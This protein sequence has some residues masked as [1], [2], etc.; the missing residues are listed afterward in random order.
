MKR[1][2]V[3]LLGVA[4]TASAQFTR[5]DYNKTVPVFSRTLTL[6]ATANDTTKP[7]DISE[8]SDI[9]VFAYS[10]DSLKAA[11][12]YRLINSVTGMKTAWTEF[13]TIVVAATGDNPDGKSIGQVLQ[14]SLGGYNGIQF[15]I[16][17]VTGTT[18]DVGAATKL[19]VYALR[20]SG[21]NTVNPYGRVPI[22]NDEK[23]KVIDEYSWL[24]TSANDTTPQPT[25]AG[26]PIFYPLNGGTDAYYFARTNDSLRATIYY[27]LINITA[28]DT[29]SFT[30]LDSV[31]TVDDLGSAT[32][33]STVRL[34][35]NAPLALSTILG[36]EGI[37]FYV[38]Y[39][40]TTP[41]TASNKDGTTNRWRLYQY[42]FRRD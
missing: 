11:Y 19:Y 37:R 5:I 16:D 14:A 15:Y 18:A 3:L 41:G 27:Q 8:A 25:T 40:A 21:G 33:D 4:V 23:F 20:R 7:F 10:T 36:Y 31:V 9:A 30:L 28:R 42:L 22:F 2:I 38:D 6:A 34:A 32:Y 26:V 17:Y 1:F 12:W 24:S 29:G 13:D 35:H 39:D